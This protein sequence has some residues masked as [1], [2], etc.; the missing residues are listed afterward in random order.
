[1][2]DVHLMLQLAIQI[3]GL[4]E[5][6]GHALAYVALG[7]LE[8]SRPERLD[9]FHPQGCNEG[10]LLIELVVA[11]GIDKLRHEE[12]LD[13]RVVT[14]QHIAARH[15]VEDRLKP[16][17]GAQL[18]RVA[19]ELAVAVGPGAVVAGVAEQVEILTGHAVLAIEERAERQILEV[20]GA[21]PHL[22][23][24]L[25]AP[26]VAV[27]QQTVVVVDGASHDLRHADV[28]GRSRSLGT[29]LVVIHLVALLT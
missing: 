11:V 4:L 16:L 24:V 7:I 1:M 29:G 12:L 17:V 8:E 10:L 2:A 9:V 25:Q 14:A 28:D 26:A 5:V 19:E 3:G 27:V 23:A 13:Q 18:L 22:D 15:Q 6:G 21:P 20:L